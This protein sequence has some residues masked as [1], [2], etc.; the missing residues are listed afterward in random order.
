LEGRLGVTERFEGDCGNCFALCCVG[1][2][3]QRS[4]D[5]GH[6]K[7]SGQACHFLEK[8]YRCRIHPQKEALGYEGCID[9]DCF[10]AGQRASAGFA[11]LNFAGDP[12]VARKLYA[13][14]AQLLAVQEMRQA[15]VDAQDLPLSREQESMRH[16]L[17]ERL[18]L[19]ADSLSA[20]LDPDAPALLAQGESFIQ[21][22]RR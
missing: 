15:L 18:A 6:D 8:D 2:S 5:F 14:F 16:G 21:I 13:R 22:L 10:G 11:G 20:E 19:G 17:L 7:P 3:F 4:T 1:L 9:F 12:T